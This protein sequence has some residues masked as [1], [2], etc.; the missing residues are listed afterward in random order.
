[1]SLAYAHR[2]LQHDC[3]GRRIFGENTLSAFQNAVRRGLGFE[4]DVRL[5]RDGVPVVVHDRSLLRTHG[6]SV[7]VSETL[8]RDLAA[9]DVPTVAQTLDKFDDE[10]PIIFD[11]KEAECAQKLAPL[12][13]RRKNLTFLYWDDKWPLPRGMLFYRA[14]GFRFPTNGGEVGIACRFNGS[15]VNLG[16]IRRALKAGHRLNLMAPRAR[17][18]DALLRMFGD[19]DRCSIT[20]SSHSQSTSRRRGGVACRLRCKCAST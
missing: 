14:R 20:L 7:R 11:L 1:M 19:D 17:H 2:G 15:A 9:Y 16:C 6:L 10:V 3:H 12:C 18:V 4:C 5:S 13:R 8:A